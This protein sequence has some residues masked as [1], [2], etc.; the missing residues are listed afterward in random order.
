MDWW[1]QFGNM[2]A[3]FQDAPAMAADLTFNGPRND[4][5]GYRM[6]YSLNATAAEF[7]PYPME[8]EMA[9]PSEEG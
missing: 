1:Q 8:S 4:A 5:F 2:A 6:A 3:F 7:D 9:F